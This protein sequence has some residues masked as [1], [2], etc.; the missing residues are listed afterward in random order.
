MD[1]EYT[2]YDNVLKTPPRKR[3]RLT[4]LPTPTS[5]CKTLDPTTVEPPSPTP[6]CPKRPK[7]TEELYNEG[8]QNA[9]AEKEDAVV[10]RPIDV[11]ATVADLH[12]FHLNRK[13]TL[14][15]IVSGEDLIG[16]ENKENHPPS[17]PLPVS[18]L[19]HEVYSDDKENRYDFLED[20]E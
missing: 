6:W 20:H 3:P 15:D 19:T 12:L 13:P 2:S 4:H 7:E 11:L 17:S 5:L 10:L 9:S 18:D 8:T 16:D 1:G 14:Y